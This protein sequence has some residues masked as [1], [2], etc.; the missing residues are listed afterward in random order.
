MSRTGPISKEMVCQNHYRQQVRRQRGLKLPGPVPQS[1]KWRS[2][3]NPDNPR[4]LKVG[5]GAQRRPRVDNEGQTIEYEEC[6]RGH[7]PLSEA[8]TYSH[9]DS[10][11][12]TCRICSLIYNRRHWYGVEPEFLEELLKAQDYRCGLCHEEFDEGTPHLDHDHGTGKVRGM[13]HLLCNRGLGDF[14]DDVD[15]LQ[16]A[17][18]YLQHPPAD[19]LAA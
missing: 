10:P 12:R 19:M 5:P 14:K 4:R 9:G 7:L 17:I 3:S 1:D 15:I 6:V 13:V 16:A 8:T 2:R 18:D 11:K